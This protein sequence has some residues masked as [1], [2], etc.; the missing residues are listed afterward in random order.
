MV[1]L[2]SGPLFDIGYYT[3]QI[4]GKESEEQAI[5]FRDWLIRISNNTYQQALDTSPPAQ[6]GSPEGENEPHPAIRRF[7]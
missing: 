7:S 4:F 5:A 2:C 1:R 3:V 6:W